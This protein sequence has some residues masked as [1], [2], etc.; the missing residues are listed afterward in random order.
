[1]LGLKE[2][3]AADATSATGANRSSLSKKKL[4]CPL[5]LK[6]HGLAR[7][8]PVAARAIQRQTKGMAKRV[9]LALVR[10]AN[11]AI[12]IT[13]PRMGRTMMMVEEIQRS[14]STSLMALVR[15]PILVWRN[16]MTLTPRLHRMTFQSETPEGE[17]R[18][19]TVYPRGGIATTERESATREAR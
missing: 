10:A 11:R 17:E 4:M 7:T 6:P 13:L 3:T 1:M 9:A 15:N 2:R 19:T 5:F 18:M 16:L 14:I 8:K 12:A